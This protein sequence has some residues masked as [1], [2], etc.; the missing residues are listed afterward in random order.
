MAAANGYADRIEFIQDMSTQVKPPEQADIV[1]S[2]MRGVLPVYEQHLSSIID[3]RRRL[4][5]PG[6][7]MIPQRDTLWIAAVEAPDLYKKHTVPWD[8][9]PYGFDMRIA[10]PVTTNTWIK[11]RVTSEQLLVEPKCWATLDY[12]TLE[13][14]DVSG[15]VT[16]TA[17]RAGTGHGFIVWF[18]T[19][20]SEGVSFS[21]APDTPELIYGS[22]YFP[23]SEPVAL[24]IGDTV[25][26]AL[27]ANLVSEDYV[28]RWD[29]YVLDQGHP[30]RVKAKFKQSTFFN[31]PVSPARLRKRA[32]DHVPT[33][34]EDGE[35]D[36]LI[37]E[38]MASGTSVGEI[39][40]R[41][42]ERFPTHF[43]RWEDALTRVGELS[44]KYSR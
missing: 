30:E 28:W 35:L 24:A 44:E 19:D 11:A 34:N 10:L 38:L 31:M 18:D 33:L 23:W 1:V 2:D 40:C 37:L 4:L 43:C 13:T 26:V 22:A 14:T 42:S 7:V 5:A 25:C 17:A 29:I 20:L 16:W 32:A 39:A 9:N 8:G 12:P 36:R 41:V 27:R 21:N 15:E 3:V 6:G